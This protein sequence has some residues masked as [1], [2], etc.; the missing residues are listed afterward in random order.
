VSVQTVELP[1]RGDGGDYYAAV[2]DR[3]WPAWLDSGRPGT[4]AGRYDIVAADPFCRLTARARQSQLDWTHGE[5]RVV[6]GDPLAVLR[7]VLGPTTGERP[8]LPFGGGAIGFLGYD[9]KRAEFGLRARDDDG[10][11]DLAVGLYDWAVVVDHVD[12]RCTW[13][14]AGRDPRG[15]GPARQALHALLRAAG[16]PSAPSASRVGAVQGQL[17][18]DGLPAATYARTFARIQRYIRDGDCYQVNFAQR[19]DARVETPPWPLYLALRRHSPAP[20]GAL[21]EYPFG[22]V[23]SMSPERFLALRDGEVVTEPIKGTRPRRADPAADAAL[24]R[25]LETS[26]KDRAENLM[27]VDLLRNDL[28]RVCEPGSINVPSLFAVESFATVHHMVSRVVGRLR[29]AHDALDLLAACFPGGSITGAPK[30]RAMQ[31][32]D[33]LE[34][35]ARGVY[36][37]SVLRLG[38][39]GCLDSSIAIRTAV[40]RDGVARYWAGGGIVADSD[41]AAEYQES[42]DK[43]AGFRRLF[44]A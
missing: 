34:D 2:R 25:E 21:L 44:D 19:F 26:A 30:R 14:R 18:R 1:Y 20:Y 43:A 31:V 22:Q 9:L 6:E 23:L 37:G 27:I 42:L 11:P 3:P 40:L 29:P 7:E 17:L 13:V 35:A 16:R 41:C 38:F 24:R 39:D 10:W 33:E 15:D 4:E 8:G 28:G 5:S 32:I 36:C 12:R